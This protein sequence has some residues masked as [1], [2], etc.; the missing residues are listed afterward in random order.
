L[1]TGLV[2]ENDAAYM[3]GRA[4]SKQLHADKGGDV[5]NRGFTKIV[6]PTLVIIFILEGA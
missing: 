6:V 5:R 3:G 1:T 2:R 4:D